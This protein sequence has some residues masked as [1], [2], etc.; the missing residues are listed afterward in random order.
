[1][2]VVGRCETREPSAAESERFGPAP[3][4]VDGELFE[5]VHLR[6]DPRFGTAHFT[7]GAARPL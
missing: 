5:P 3:R 7:A 6:V 4:Q 2:Q 1:M